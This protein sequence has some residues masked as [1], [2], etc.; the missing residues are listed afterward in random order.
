MLILKLL[1]I[2]LVLNQHLNH[3]MAADNGAAGG[4]ET[5]KP[6]L[7]LTEIIIQ[8]EVPG[9][10]GTPRKSRHS[11]SVPAKPGIAGKKFDYFVLT[12]SWP[13]TICGKILIGKMKDAPLTTF[14]DCIGKLK[15]YQKYRKYRFTIHG[16][17]PSEKKQGVVGWGPVDCSLTGSLNELT[18]DSYSDPNI[19]LYWPSFVKEEKEFWKSEWEKHGRCVTKHPL[20]ENCV[21]YF[22]WTLRLAAG[23]DR[24][25][26]NLRQTY[27]DLDEGKEVVTRFEDLRT[28][29]SRQHKGEVVIQYKKIPVKG[30]TKE[31]KNW[32]ESLYFCY[33]L[34]FEA[35]KC[36]INNK[37]NSFRGEVVLP[38]INSLENVDQSSV[39]ASPA[40]TVKKPPEWRGASYTV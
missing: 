15:H 9:S 19:Y 31:E 39:P 27:R 14:E 21:G 12:M 38:T 30:T 16:L 17:W 7:K 33:D 35:I 29:L 3:S 36:P 20:V 37:E 34:G 28:F 24:L 18:K 11:L 13:T 25:Q 6:A 4:Q 2:L 22:R 32:V 23:L 1:V 26:E 5:N 10:A 8:E 40:R